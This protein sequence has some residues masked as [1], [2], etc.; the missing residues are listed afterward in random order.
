MNWS[1]CT[2]R[3]LTVCLFPRER[4]ILEE[5]AINTIT[6]IVAARTLGKHGIRV[7]VTDKRAHWRVS[8]GG[9]EANGGLDT[10]RS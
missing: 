10:R 6:P 2:P 3:L 4:I 7:P 9:G 5:C 8:G 1:I